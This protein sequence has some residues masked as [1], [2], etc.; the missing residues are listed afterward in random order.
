MNAKRLLPSLLLIIAGY[1]IAAGQYTSTEAV[2]TLKN[3]SADLAKTEQKENE[4]LEWYVNQKADHA[5]GI[6]IDLQK[7][8]K[9]TSVKTETPPP[10]V[11]IPAGTRKNIVRSLSK[12]VDD[13]LK[14]PIP[15]SPEGIDD[16]QAAKLALHL[17]AIIQFT[18]PGQFESRKSYPLS[19][20]DLLGA[21][22]RTNPVSS[23]DAMEERAM[24]L[25][26]KRC[27]DF[28]LN[29]TTSWAFKMAGASDALIREVDSC[30]SPAQRVAITDRD[31]AKPI[32]DRMS[33]DA[34]LIGDLFRTLFSRKD[35]ESRKRCIEVGREFIRRFEHYEDARELV[36]YLK[37]WI[38]KTEDKIAAEERSRKQY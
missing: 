13:L 20:S 27:V 28:V 24:N 2:K 25:V 23:P 34:V 17:N 35:I 32:S 9:L 8:L 15:E 37:I 7:G 5:R 19:V 3:L 26:R 6:A 33:D 38:P 29:E 4:P 22:A 16:K 1:S 30:I 18:D 21:F 11:E 10:P 14:D 31:A 12:L 36:D